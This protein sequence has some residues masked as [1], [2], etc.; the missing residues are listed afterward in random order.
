MLRLKLLP[1]AKLT[2]VLD[3]PSSLVNGDLRR[4][5]QNL[6]AIG[7]PPVSVLVELGMV[8]AD[9][10][11]P[12]P[13]LLADDRLEALVEVSLAGLGLAVPLV[14]EHRTELVLV[15]LLSAALFGRIV[16]EVTL[17]AGSDLGR[18]DL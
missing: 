8:E 16:A 11:G 7:A 14:A 1:V 5:E 10:P 15:Q 6:L 2:Q 13:L 3:V 9:L 12:S 17:V 4:A 18:R